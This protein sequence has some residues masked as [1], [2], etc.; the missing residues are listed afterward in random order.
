MKMV[1][2]P[3]YQNLS[4]NR[5]MKYQQVHGDDLHQDQ[6][7][8]GVYLSTN[9]KKMQAPADMHLIRSVILC[10]EAKGNTKQLITQQKNIES[11]NE[12]PVWY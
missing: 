5:K 8:H 6:K 12:V 9:Q 10:P 4:I 3:M 11:G 2:Y 7:V 1:C